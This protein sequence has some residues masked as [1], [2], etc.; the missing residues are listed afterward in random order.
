M[1]GHV[2]ELRAFACRSQQHASAAHVAA[3]YEL[4]GKEQALAQH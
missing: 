4:A 3:A 2:V 1:H